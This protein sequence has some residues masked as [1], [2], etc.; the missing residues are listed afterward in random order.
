MHT[1]ALS[2]MLIKASIITCAGL[3]SELADVCKLHNAS[4]PGPKLG[5]IEEEKGNVNHTQS[6]HTVNKSTYLVEVKTSGL[7]KLH[8]VI[9]VF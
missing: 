2:F 8:F 9:F 5:K 1:P 6:I 3:L 7:F 4:C